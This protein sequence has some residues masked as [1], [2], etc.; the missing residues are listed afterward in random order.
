VAPAV[1]TL[2]T[3]ALYAIV[4]ADDEHHAR[5][6]AARNA[7]SGPYYIPA[8]ILAEIAYILEANLP[9]TALQGLLADLISGAYTLDCGQGDFPRISEL[10]GRYASLQLGFSDAATIAC[11][12]RHAGRVLTADRRHFDVVAAGEKSVIALPAY[13]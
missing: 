13:E 7:D 3:S 6:V 9:L 4:R 12:E 10:V 8:G 5:M 2:D 1:L 11:S